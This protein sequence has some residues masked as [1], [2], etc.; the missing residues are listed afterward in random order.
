MYL[1]LCVIPSII[2]APGAVYGLLPFRVRYFQEVFFF[3]L[4][5]V[6][7]RFNP[8]TCH[9]TLSHLSGRP[10]WKE[11]I[12]RGGHGPAMQRGPWSLSGPSPHS[13]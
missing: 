6:A 11:M 2:V 9:C 12:I 3:F 5:E 13:A 8:L 1:D 10:P 4:S 7:L